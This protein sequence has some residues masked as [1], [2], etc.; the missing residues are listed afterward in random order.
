MFK[1]KNKFYK[2]S[3]LFSISLILFS[4]L[5]AAGII[6]GANMYYDI[7]TG[8]VMVNEI[9]RIVKTGANALEVIGTAIFGSDTNYARFSETGDLSFVGTADTISKTDAA[10]AIQTTSQ[11]LTLQTVT[12]GTLAATAANAMELTGGANS[13]IDFPNF[14]VATTGNI[15]VQPAY[16]LDTNAAGILALGNTT[17]TTVN[18][19]NT[20]ATTIAIGAG[21]ALTRAINI[22]TGTGI[23]TIKIGTGGTLA[24]DIDIGDAL[25]DVDINGASQLIAGTGDPLTI[26]ANA[27]STWSTSAGLLSI[28]GTGGITLTSTGGTLTINAAGQT[29]DLDSAALDVD[30]TGAITIDTSSGNAITINATGATFTLKTTTSGEIVLDPISGGAGIIRLGA[31]DQILTSG[32]GAASRLSGEQILRA[33]VPIFGFDLPARTSSTAYKTVSRVLEADPFAAALSGTDRTYKLIIRYADNGTAGTTS[34]SICLATIADADCTET[35]TVPAS[36]TV[37]LDKGNVNITADLTLPA[38]PWRI[39]VKNVASVNYPTTIQIY[40]LFFAA[41]DQVQ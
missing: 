16:G 40:Q 31:G 23:D 22:G 28:T 15:T 10:L 25:A 27:A 12:G 9:Q 18:I 30:A 13:K 7:D 29:I 35:F 14:D 5:I 39:A 20:A 34:W 26:T 36:T 19:G 41:Y 11:N 24:D 37:D 2:G 8:K 1:I 4:G 17:A 21:G 6:W 33:I 3:K 38:Y 32:G